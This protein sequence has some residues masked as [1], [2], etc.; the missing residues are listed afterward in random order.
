MRLW[1]SVPEPGDVLH[2]GFEVMAVELVRFEDL[3][4]S[5]LG[6]GPAVGRE[7]GCR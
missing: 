1:I 7:L 5:N 2:N 6:T 4:E 3:M